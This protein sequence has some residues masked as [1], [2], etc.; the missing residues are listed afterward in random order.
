M[1][2]PEGTRD[3]ACDLRPAKLTTNIAARGLLRK[4]M[5][6]PILVSCLQ[7]HSLLPSKTS[8]IQKISTEK[9]ILL[10]G[11]AGT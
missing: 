6:P 10:N 8:I 11:F 5:I 2:S 3:R 7:N 4:T 1:R 9:N